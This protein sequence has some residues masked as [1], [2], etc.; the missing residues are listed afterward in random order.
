MYVKVYRIY[1]YTACANYISISDE[2]SVVMIL[3]PT[4]KAVAFTLV[5]GVV[6]GTRG[7]SL[8]V[9]TQNLISW[10]IDLGNLA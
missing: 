2:V 1:C 8:T 5:P 6:M 3:P 10:S 7:K 9:K 4:H